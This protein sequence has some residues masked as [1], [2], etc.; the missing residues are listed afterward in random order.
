MPNALSCPSGLD[1]C[2][3]M[4]A[5]GPTMHSSRILN[6]LLRTTVAAF[7]ALGIVA[8]SA[9]NNTTDSREILVMGLAAFTPEEVGDVERVSNVRHVAPR[10]K[11]RTPVRHRGAELEASVIAQD[12]RPTAEL[13]AHA[14][15]PLETGTFIDER[16]RVDG[17]RVALI[18][19]PVRDRLFGSEVTA[20]GKSILINDESFTV[21]GVL[22][23]HPPFVDAIPDTA[24]IPLATRLYVPLRTG[25]EVLFRDA[26]PRLLR[27][28]VDDSQRLD[29][30]IGEIR[31]VLVGRHGQAL[32]VEPVAVTQRVSTGP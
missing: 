11:G 8:A 25:V 27:V 6:R 29:Q 13:S 19:G 14:A 1:Y 26:R 30:T 2:A 10:Y 9:A 22:G 5:L 28:S 24:A 23:P 3:V 17:K 31:Q 18:G 12:A 4:H 21:K 7:A 20:V 15:W 16:D 32:H